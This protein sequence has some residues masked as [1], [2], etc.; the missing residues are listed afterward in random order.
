MSSMMRRSDGRTEHLLWNV[1]SLRCIDFNIDSA[2]WFGSL[3]PSEMAHFSY[4]KFPR[5]TRISRITRTPNSGESYNPFLDLKNY[6]LVLFYSDKNPRITRTLYR[7][8]WYQMKAD[9]GSR[10]TRG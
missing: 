7:H 10:I 4:R 8:V 9:I 5:I 3:N 1:T 2:L 6:I